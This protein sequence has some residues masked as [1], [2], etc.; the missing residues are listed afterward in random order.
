MSATAVQGQARSAPSIPG[1]WL[2]ELFESDFVRTLLQ[3]KSLSTEPQT[4]ARPVF[5]PAT[6]TP[7]TETSDA[8]RMSR[9]EASDSAEPLARMPDAALKE[10][11]EERPSPGVIP[12]T[13]Q[14]LARFPIGREG[15]PLP[16]IPYQ[17]EDEFDFEHVEEKEE[18]DPG[19]RDG[20]ADG[21]ED[22]PAEAADEDADAADAVV[23]EEGHPSD[24]PSE[25]YAPESMV[26][27]P[28]ALPAPSAAA[29]PLP[30]EPAHELYLRMAGLT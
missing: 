29:L 4:S 2:A 21:N 17:L 12:L 15:M 27:E 20:E 16:F 9:D 30:P 10:A 18:E 19:S 5:V 26:A 13:E 11:A 14:A 23:A 25:P 6:D 22:D 7:L 28:H 24:G 8:Q 1:G 3:L